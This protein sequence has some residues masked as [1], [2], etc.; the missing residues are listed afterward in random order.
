MK[1]VLIATFI[2]FFSFSNFLSGQVDS[3]IIKDIGSVLIEMQSDDKGILVPRLTT[4]ERTG[5]IAIPVAGL[6]VYDITLKDFCY[7]DGAIWNCG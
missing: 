5:S 7:F 1:Q 6:L 3:V 4:S 2:I